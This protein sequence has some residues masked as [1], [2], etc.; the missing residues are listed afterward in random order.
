MQENAIKNLINF[1]IRSENIVDVDHLDV[2]DIV[3]STSKS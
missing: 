2:I 1:A 3:K